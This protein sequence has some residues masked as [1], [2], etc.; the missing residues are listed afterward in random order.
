MPEII[1]KLAPSRF[2][3]RVLAA[4]PG[5]AAELE[6]PAPFTRAQMLNALE[7][8]GDDKQK[9]RELRN[10]VL[11]RVMARDLAGRADLAEVC[12]TMSDLADVAVQYGLQALGAQDLVVVGMGKLGGRELNVS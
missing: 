6:D 11:L 10:R 12:G 7:A 1:Q 2:A 3:E 8:P 5:L 4:R 9:L